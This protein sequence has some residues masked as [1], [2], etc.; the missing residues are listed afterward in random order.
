MNFIRKALVGL[1]FLTL[2]I[3]AYAADGVDCADGMGG[4]LPVDNS[5][6]LQ[7]K[8]STKNQFLS[9]S[10]ISGT[11]LKVLE[12]R[13]GHVHF[14]AKIGSVVNAGDL[15]NSDTIEVVYN[16]EFG[17][18]NSRDLKEGAPVQA[19]G[20]YITSTQPTERYQASPACGIIHWVHQ[21]LRA[22]SSHADGFMRINGNLYGF[23]PTEKA[24]HDAEKHDQKKDNESKPKPRRDRR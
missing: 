7:W 23:L 16:V 10:N 15:C 18:V 22:S 13:N 8:R 20:D 4:F 17:V 12:N 9:R 21:N 3:A 6:V 19:C 5:P 14:I 1:V 24:K 11:I 2:S